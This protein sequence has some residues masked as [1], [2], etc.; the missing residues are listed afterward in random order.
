MGCENILVAVDIAD[1]AEQLLSAAQELV[2]DEKSTLSVITVMR[3]ITDFYV[4]I[5]LFLAIDSGKNIETDAMKHAST[6]LSGL[7]AQFGIDS[8]N[9]NVVLGDPRA[10]IQRIAENTQSDLIVIGSHERHGVGRVLGS[11]AQS[12]LNRV[13]CDVLVVK[14]LRSDAG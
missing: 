3:P 6:W 11:T 2:A 14:L 4:K 8:Q 7:A 13:H 1:E 10:E 12:L 5:N 9:I